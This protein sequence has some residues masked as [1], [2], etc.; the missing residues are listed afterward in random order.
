[1]HER[2][3]P[4]ARDW[5]LLAH[6]ALARASRVHAEPIDLIWREVCARYAR[7]HAIGYPLVWELASEGL[8][9]VLTD[10]LADDRAD[11]ARSGYAPLEVE[12]PLNGVLGGGRDIPIRGR[13][14]RIDLG[15]DGRLRVI[16]W[17]LQWSRSVNRR[18]DLV[19][20]ALR[21]QALQSPLYAAL[22]REYAS[23]RGGGDGLPVDVAVYAVRPRAN[24][25]PVERTW[26]EPNA[27]AAERIGAT[28]ATLVDGIEAGAFPMI[29]DGYCAWCAF[30][31]ACRR[32]H[33]PSRARAERDIRTARV[34]GLRSAPVRAPKVTP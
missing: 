15:T 10:A 14:D 9:R 16:D 25:P 21:G 17:K 3:G 32:R 13:L 20:A 11:L 31:A 7:R 24:D 4:T 18:A 33:A 26:Y 27:D 28:I 19:A 12:V 30:S 1:V 8:G 23:A 6:E 29:P 34:A 22:A 2:E 5:G